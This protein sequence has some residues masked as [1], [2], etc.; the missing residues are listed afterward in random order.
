MNNKE[1]HIYDFK[2]FQEQKEAI[3]VYEQI[4]MSKR[5]IEMYEKKIEAHQRAIDNHKKAIDTERDTL[6]KLYIQAGYEQILCYY[7]GCRGSFFID[8]NEDTTFYK[9]PKCKQLLDPNEY[10]MPF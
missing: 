7:K 6:T 1:K 5:T 9:C 2:K 8:P 4:R 10:V 3:T